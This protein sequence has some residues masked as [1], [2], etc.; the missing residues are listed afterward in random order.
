MSDEVGIDPGAVVHPKA[1]IGRGVLIGPF[2]VIGPD[3]TIGDRSRL[4]SHVVVQ[5]PTELG[6]DNVISPMASIGGPP[7]DLKY[8]GAPT[9]LVVGARNKIRE[10]VTLN[11]GTEGGGGVTTVGDDNLFM[12]QAHVG[13]D[14]RVHNRTIF[15]NGVT[16]GG[17]VEVGDDAS[18][19]AYSGVHQYCR[20]A[21]HGFIGG[22]SVVTRDAMPWV[23]TAGD[24]AKSHGLNIVGLKRKGYS[25]EVIAALKSCYMQLFRSKTL[26]A[27]AMQ[28]VEQE[29][30]QFE[31]VRYFLEFV[32]TSTRGVC[33]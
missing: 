8:R 16:L 31:E 33:R 20:V 15:G 12:A 21:R 14:S 26:L 28:K 18:I 25:N 6:P 3:V 19:G 17:H 30:G 2:C 13:H 11:R 29:L 23:M 32:R 24:R 5:G 22:Y 27:E 4:E 10:Y 9:R 7:Q 1:D